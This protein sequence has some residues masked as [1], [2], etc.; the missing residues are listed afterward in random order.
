MRLHL[1]R[2]DNRFFD[3]FLDQARLISKASQALIDQVTGLPATLVACAAEIT[4]IEHQGDAIVQR[5]HLD[6]NRSF[7]MRLELDPEDI[8]VLSSRLDDVLDGIEDA[9]HRLMAYRIESVPQRIV[10]VCKIICACAKQILA[11]LE[12]LGRGETVMA[13]CA[14]IN[15]LEHEAD[16]MVRSAITDLFDT[17]KDAIRLLRVKEAFEFLEFT[18]DRCEDVADVLENIGAKN[19]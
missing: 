18:V 7:L 9:G 13:R 1:L 6:L 5:V 8:Y 12:E 4:A 17:E 11:A 16:V 2:R 10:D 3:S 14:E 15:H 19:R